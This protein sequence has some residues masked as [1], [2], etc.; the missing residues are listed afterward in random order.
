M[1][2]SVASVIPSASLSYII[3][4]QILDFI[5]INQYVSLSDKDLN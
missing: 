5:A 1:A 4:K 2:S 3:L